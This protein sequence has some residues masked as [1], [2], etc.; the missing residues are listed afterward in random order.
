[1]AAAHRAT[2]MNPPPPQPMA[3]TSPANKPKKRK[4]V[5]R[6]FHKTG[7]IAGPLDPM[8]SKD[9]KRCTD[10]VVLK[11][12]NMP[13][14]G[15]NLEPSGI[16]RRI[17]FMRTWLNS[18]PEFLGLRRV[19]GLD[20]FSGKMEVWTP[21]SGRGSRYS[22]LCTASGCLGFRGESSTCADVSHRIRECAKWPKFACL[23]R[24]PKGNRYI[25]KCF[26]YAK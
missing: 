18:L 8:S 19:L 12:N 5:H 21:F 2:Q 9:G 1:M 4:V 25:C 13:P 7:G 17:D 20:H 10:D 22:F 3:S 16:L 11:W 24:K 26:G 6:P 14:P 23:K 15:I